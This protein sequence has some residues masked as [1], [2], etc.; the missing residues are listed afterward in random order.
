MQHNATQRYCIDTS[1]LVEAWVRRYPMEN[2]PALWT[3]IEDLIKGGRLLASEWVK[4]ELEKS[5]DDLWAW[6]KSQKQ[7]FVPS[8]RSI[9]AQAANIVNRFHRLTT[10]SGSANAADPFV[11]AAAQV[12]GLIVVTEEKPAEAQQ[13]LR[14][15]PDICRTLSVPCTN[16]LGLIKGERWVFG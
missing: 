16:I 9:Q 5:D 2:F 4:F 1:S 11:V 13:K 10:G 12:Y 14:K 15:M 3:R 7:L 6:C 8:T